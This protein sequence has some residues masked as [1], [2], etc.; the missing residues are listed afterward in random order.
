MVPLRNPNQVPCFI[1]L[2]HWVNNH[3][4]MEK[5]GYKSQEISKEENQDHNETKEKLIMKDTIHI[6][7][8]TDQN[9]I[10]GG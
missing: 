6:N 3:E 8:T 1:K 10:Q 4:K 5:E 7:K 9:H 2:N